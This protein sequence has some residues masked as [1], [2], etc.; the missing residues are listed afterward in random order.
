[1][2]GVPAP[3]TSSQ[4]GQILAIIE[5]ITNAEACKKRFL[6]L[7]EAEKQIA[8]AMTLSLKASDK[9]GEQ[10]A[11]ANKAIAEAD[12]LQEDLMGQAE[13]L[14]REQTL[15]TAKRKTLEQVEADLKLR[16]SEVEVVSK[17]NSADIDN[18]EKAFRANV[19]ATE[20][21][22]AARERAVADRETAAAAILKK[23]EDLKASYEQKLRELRNLAA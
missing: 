20:Q 7:Q 4:S 15:L 11:A 16:A 22:M 17:R 14:A 2:M 5:L 3:A 21:A 9:A 23:A 19:A 8:E 1:M 12:R 6:E 10:L 13:N 18:R